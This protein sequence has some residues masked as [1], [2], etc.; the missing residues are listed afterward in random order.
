MNETGRFDIGVD[1]PNELLRRDLTFEVSMDVTGDFQCGT[2]SPSSLTVDPASTITSTTG[3]PPT[4]E[5][6]RHY[7]SRCCPHSMSV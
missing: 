7:R 1:V 5:D 3:F 6:S 4:L 2:S